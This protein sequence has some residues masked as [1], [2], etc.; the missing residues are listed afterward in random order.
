MM[1]QR[2]RESDALQH[3]FR[4]SAKPPVARFCQSDEL[5]QFVRALFQCRASES[6]KSAKKMQR[7][8]AGEIFIEIRV[9]R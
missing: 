6:A 4:I 7:F 5:E 8:L 3:P 1:N 9:L 2:L